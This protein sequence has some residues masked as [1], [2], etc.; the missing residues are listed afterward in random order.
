MHTYKNMLTQGHAF[1]YSHTPTLAAISNLCQIV[2][3]DRE[4][5][6]AVSDPPLGSSM[7]I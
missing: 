1:N 4:E 2:P 5:M 6:L 7:S 3:W